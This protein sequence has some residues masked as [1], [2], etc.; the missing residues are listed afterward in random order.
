MY[1]SFYGL[2]K[3]PFQVSSDPS[4]LWLGEKHN[5]ALATLKYGNFGNQGFIL[6]TGDV[7][8][9][10]TTLINALINSLSD[11]VIVARV[12]D[13]GMEIIDFMNYISHAFGMKK[14]FV[15][16]NS[17]LIHFDHFLNSAHATGKKVLLIIDEAQRLSSALLEEIRQLSNIEKQETKLLSIFFVGQSE[18]RDVLL[19]HKNRALRQRISLN[20]VIEPLDMQETGEFIRHRLNV[21]GAEEEIFSP[22]AIRD[23]YEFSGGFPR[24]VNIICDHALLLGFGEG[25]KTITG[26]IVKECAKDLLL[27]EF[28]DNKQNE[29]LQF[30]Q[31]AASENFEMIPA[32]SIQ[33]VSSG[34]GWITFITVVLIVLAIVIVT[35][36]IYPGKNRNL[37]SHGYNN[38]M[39]SNGGA[40]GGDILSAK[41]NAEPDR[42]TVSIKGDD[43][44]SATGVA[45]GGM[46]KVMTTEKPLGEDVQ[47]VGAVSADDRPDIPEKTPI[48]PGLLD[49]PVG[50][51]GDGKGRRVT[52]SLPNAKV[53]SFSEPAEKNPSKEKETQKTPIISASDKVVN[54]KSENLD[55]G[56]LIDWVIQKRS[57]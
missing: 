46:Q 12:P 23:V 47:P 48:V 24:R 39:S 14:E 41:S 42:E 17:F 53:I 45:D 10:K 38:E 3:K 22:D 55:P 18:F 40:H 5:E 52:G 19:E 29:S 57:N 50:I 28:S 36:I 25:A 49:K 15:C 56:A 1:L 20:Y 16:K 26:E 9:G 21:A 31:T 34:K 51:R 33:K 11:E 4:F 6:L 13:P 44:S 43:K 27:S 35:V 8:T 2:Q 30:A 32:E 37:F 54:K 7:G